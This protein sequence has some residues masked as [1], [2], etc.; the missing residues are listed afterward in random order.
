MKDQHSGPKANFAEAVRHVRTPLLYSNQHD[1][2]VSGQ[3][4]SAMAAIIHT[5][6]SNDSVQYVVFP[7]VGASKPRNPPKRAPLN[8]GEKVCEAPCRCKR[9]CLALMA[10]FSTLEKLQTSFWYVLLPHGLHLGCGLGKK[11]GQKLKAWAD[12]L[13][14]DHYGEIKIQWRRVVSSQL[15]RAKQ[16]AEIIAQEL[17][18]EVR[19]GGRQQEVSASR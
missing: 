11:T 15:L 19:D 4:L 12:G 7:R 6:L 2:C 9:A 13:K 17:G 16:T 10:F 8:A 3:N 18:C 14:K 5:L 1:L